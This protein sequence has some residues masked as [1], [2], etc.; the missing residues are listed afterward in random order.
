[1]KAEPTSCPLPNPVQRKRSAQPQQLM[2][3]PTAHTNF[4]FF[5]GP[6]F[7][8]GF[9]GPGPFWGVGPFGG[10]W[11]GAPFWGPRRFWGPGFGRR[12]W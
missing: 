12:F 4:G 1:M 2:Q 7:G 8:G 9:W 5:G 3:E 6:F 11:G 10:G